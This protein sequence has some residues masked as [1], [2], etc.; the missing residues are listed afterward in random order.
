MIV[1]AHLVVYFVMEALSFELQKNVRDI[2]REVV[3]C[4]N[5]AK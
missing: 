3:V 2:T 4:L 1:C 5:E